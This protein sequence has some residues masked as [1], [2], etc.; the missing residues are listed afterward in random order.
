APEERFVAETLFVVFLMVLLSNVAS[1]MQYGA[2]AIGAPYADPWLAAADARIGVY[3]PALAA[4]TRAHPAVSLAATL[5]YAT[6]LPQFLLTTIVLAG[7]RERERLWE[8]AFHL[9]VCM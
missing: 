6:L 2:V 3:V 9:H 8:F 1:P 7:L 5:T 4:W